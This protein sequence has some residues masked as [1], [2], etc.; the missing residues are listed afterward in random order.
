[1]GYPLYSPQVNNDSINYVPGAQLLTY[2][3]A[4]MVGKAGSIPAYRVIQ[5]GYTAIAAFIA[6]VCCRRIL[7]LGV[8]EL[9]GG[10]GWLWNSFWYA[11][12]LLIATNPITN[13]FAHNMHAD[14]LAEVAN[15]AAFY[16]LLRY[17]R[18]PPAGYWPPW[19]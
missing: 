8:P 7:R 19:W 12:L 2:W 9:R 15:L 10:E 17:I 4:W 16:L 1:V 14:A 3:L 5:V 11:T 18:P 13:H 6:T